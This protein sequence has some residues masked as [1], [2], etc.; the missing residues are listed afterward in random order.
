MNIPIQPF[1][2]VLFLGI[3]CVNVWL[4]NTVIKSVEADFQRSRC[5]P[6]VLP[7]SASPQEDGEPTP[8]CCCRA[9][10]WSE[11]TRGRRARLQTADRGDGAGEGERGSWAS[12]R[13]RGL[14]S[15][16]MI[17]AGAADLRRLEAA[18]AAYF[19][20]PRL[21]GHCHHVFTHFRIAPN[22]NIWSW[23]QS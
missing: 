23:I 2:S 4:K 15:C 16:C 19:K 12:A 20:L 13:A 9:D 18:A 11:E 1:E 21:Q 5:R 3:C 8:C 7:L 22:T 14:G 10:N 17:R 6:E